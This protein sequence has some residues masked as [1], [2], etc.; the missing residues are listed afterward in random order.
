MLMANAEALLKASRRHPNAAAAL[1]A[2]AGTAED[3]NWQSLAEVR[4]T[5][6]HADGVKTESGA[7]VTVFNIRGNNYRL[8]ARISYRQR[9]VAVIDLLTHAEYS[10]DKWRKNL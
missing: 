9:I 3:A 8:L 4:Q 10:K 5:Y 6:P 1:A 2:W 7:I